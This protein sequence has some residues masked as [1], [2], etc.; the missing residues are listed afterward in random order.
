M[1]ARARV[2]RP[3]TPQA[4]GLAPARSYPYRAL[5]AALARILVTFEPSSGFGG[6]KSRQSPPKPAPRRRRRRGARFDFLFAASHARSLAVR[7]AARPCADRHDRRTANDHRRDPVT[8]HERSGRFDHLCEDT[9]ERKF[10]RRR[11]SWRATRTGRRDVENLY[12]HGSDVGPLC[13][14]CEGA[15]VLPWVS[16]PGMPNAE[17]AA[18]YIARDCDGG[19]VLVKIVCE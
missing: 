18:A 6:R 8:W 7:S 3:H 10:L 2:S 17:A 15:V 14:Y 11:S 19:L 9:Q 5:V 16:I 12:R 13:W 1:H 4:Y